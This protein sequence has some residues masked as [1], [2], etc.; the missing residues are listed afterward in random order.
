MP[1]TL[2]FLAVI[3]D[4]TTLE[5]N[6]TSACSSKM[7]ALQRH[8]K[9][10]GHVIRI[11]R[12]GICY[13][14][15]IEKNGGSSLIKAIKSIPDRN[16]PVIVIRSQ[17]GDANV[18]L[19]I[20]EAIIHRKS[21]VIDYDYCISSCANYVL[22]SGYR[23]I[24]NR[25]AVLGFHGGAESVS[26]SQILFAFKQMGVPNPLQ[27]A[28]HAQLGLNATAHRQSVFLDKSGIS[29][30][31]FDWIN[32]FNN[33]P[34]KKRKAICSDSSNYIVFSPTFLSSFGYHLASYKGPSSP[35]ELRK[36]LVRIGDAASAACYVAYQHRNLR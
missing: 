11:G 29:E 30:K 1:L 10:S 17:G 15:A 12:S 3:S 22:A 20:A 28:R 19:D 33:L 6:V 25:D 36:A 23:K 8:T 27:L 13:D 26:F 4:L 18:G 34:D 32:D 2:A 14:G 5:A 9:S 31:L 35:I 21:S 24:V 7:G 16:S